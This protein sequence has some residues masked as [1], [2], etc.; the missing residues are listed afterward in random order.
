MSELK[1]NLGNLLRPYFK[2]RLLL[3]SKNKAEDIAQKYIV[4]YKLRGD[5]VTKATAETFHQ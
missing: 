1:V 3:L 2:F 5:K 4:A